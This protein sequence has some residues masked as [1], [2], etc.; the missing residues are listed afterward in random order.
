[1]LVSFPVGGVR[2]AEAITEIA[3]T[4]EVL[5]ASVL[6]DGEKAPHAAAS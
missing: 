6:S 2:R 4:P 5:D 1:M 3:G